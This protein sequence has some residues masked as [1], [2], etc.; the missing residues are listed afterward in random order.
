MWQTF[1]NQQEYQVGITKPTQLSITKFLQKCVRKNGPHHHRLCPID[2]ILMA[3]EEV[4][5][6]T[7]LFISSASRNHF[8]QGLISLT[9][10]SS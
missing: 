6:P 9:S 7:K 1:E 5:G 8:I 10:L 2:E 4:C 3:D